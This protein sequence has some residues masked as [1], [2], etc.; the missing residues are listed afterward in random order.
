MGKYDKYFITRAKEQ[1][2]PPDKTMKAVVLHPASVNGEESA[3]IPGAFLMESQIVVRPTDPAYY[4]CKPHCHDFDEYMVFASTDPDDIENLGGEVEFYYEGERHIVTKSTAIF[5]P[6][7]TM[8]LPCN[9]LRVDRPF[10]WT[11]TATTTKYRIFQYSDDPKYAN[12]GT[13]SPITEVTL[14]DGKYNVTKSYLDYLEW[15]KE[16]NRKERGW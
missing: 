16:K 4:T 13:R 15:E 2:S 6:K 1:V 11:T 10:V 5:L 9:F 14:G 12:E 8:H 7:F 3:G